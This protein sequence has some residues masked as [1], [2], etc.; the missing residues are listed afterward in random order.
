MPIVMD[1]SAV[2]LGEYG[3]IIHFTLFLIDSNGTVQYKKIGYS[4]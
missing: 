4:K 3:V 2:I 1:N